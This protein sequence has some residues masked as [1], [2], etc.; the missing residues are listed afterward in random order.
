MT[1]NVCIVNPTTA[2]TLKVC[3]KID[4]II[5]SILVFITYEILSDSIMVDI[6]TIQISTVCRS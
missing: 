4:L 6:N 2:N 3:A 5:V 1:Y